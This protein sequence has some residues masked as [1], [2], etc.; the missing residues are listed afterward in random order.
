[1]YGTWG[2]DM[3]EF[4]PEGP[5]HQEPGFD[6]YLLYVGRLDRMKGL[7]DLLA[8]AAEL[9]P[10]HPGLGLVLVGSGS[11]EIAL[12][13]RAETLGIAERVR[14]KGAILNRDLPLYFRGA[15]AFVLPSVTTKAWEEQVGM[16]NLQAMAC[17]RPVISTTSGAIPEYVPD[18]VCG[19]LVPERD[20]AALAGALLCVLSTPDLAARLGS[21]GR[22]LAVA[23][24]DS[25]SNVAAAE[26]ALLGL[27]APS[28]TSYA[29]GKSRHG[30]FHHS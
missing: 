26:K 16:T 12:R 23:R 20:P 30:L 18:G 1:M 3:A 21:A 5:A 14:F 10:H 13:Q 2:V 9:L 24:Y 27:L 15:A 17:G 28:L 4:C 29:Q 25:R 11:D 8:A 6:R 19:I 7:F 22:T